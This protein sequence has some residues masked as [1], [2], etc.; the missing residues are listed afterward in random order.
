MTENPNRSHQARISQVVKEIDIIRRVMM[1]Q[2]K[3]VAG[4]VPPKPSRDVAGQTRQE[5]R[6]MEKTRNEFDREKTERTAWLASSKTYPAMH[7]RTEDT[8]WA[9]NL[10]S[11]NRDPDDFAKL[12]PL[13]PGGFAEFFV[14]EC[15]SLLERRDN[16][17]A[18][19]LLET[20]RIENYVR[21]LLPTSML[22]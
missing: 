1:D 16:E 7:H 3:V 10:S 5:A 14:G 12:S 9:H 21:V 18:G 15:M 2:K 11:S 4:M 13:D 17:F 19:F 6:I 20:S 22:I 8:W